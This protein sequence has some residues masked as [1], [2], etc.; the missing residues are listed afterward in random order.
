MIDMTSDQA[1]KA[2]EKI[3]S[4]SSKNEKE[5]LVKQYL[6]FATFK[7]VCVC[8]YDPFL[9]YGMDKVPAREPEKYAPGETQFTG[10]VWDMLD[11]MAKRALTGNAAR[12]E[13]HKWMQLL[14]PESSELLK[15]I[16]K[17]DLRAGFTDGTLNRVHKGLVSE[18]PY[19]RCS[20]VKDVKLATW[21][22]EQGVISQEKADGMF[23]NVDHEVG[24]GGVRITS[25]QGT[26]FP[27]VELE[28][29]VEAIRATLKPGT[30]T[31]GELL[32]EFR[33][34]D[35]IW[36]TLPREQGNGLLNSI[37]Q[38]GLLEDDYRVLFYAWD[39]IPL[40]AVQP[41][42]KFAQGYKSRLTDLLAQIKAR[43]ANNDAV[44]L[45]Q[46]RV[47]KSLAEAYAHYR[48]LLAVGKE[49]TIIKHPAATW[50]DGTSKEQVKL[51]L[52]VDVDLRAKK[53]VPGTGKNE[54]TFGS[55]RFESEDGLLVVDVSG[56]TDARR[57]ELH[58]K[59]E[60][61]LEQIGTV[62]ANSIMV[63]SEEGK[64]YSLFLPRIVEFPRADK[65]EADSL[66]RVK[67]Q[68]EAAVR[69]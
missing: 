63:P 59:R 34:S 3:A 65:R 62:K 54:A 13:V 21:P 61:V 67:E 35:G 45:I 26:P 25:R 2:I 24:G 15:R 46:T 52:E 12:E 28:D 18:F 50:K 11:S 58:A 14:T 19:M 31:H 7:R 57:K 39:Q 51:K 5:A 29:L 6:Q 22:W 40:A 69:A 56:F 64:P 43:P 44:R 8:A 37:A 42:G 66:Q 48:E 17:K 23:A 16:I 32:V 49:G 68:F 33:R 30:Q 10:A 36:Q 60:E 38:D 41:K 20:L 4:V 9:T 55:I 1:F 27:L 47:V 53:F